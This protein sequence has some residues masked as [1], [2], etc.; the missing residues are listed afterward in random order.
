VRR[1]SA[2]F[3]LA[4]R[5]AVWRSR[6]LPRC[7]MDA[8]GAAGDEYEPPLV[9]VCGVQV[10]QLPPPCRVWHAA[11]RA[12]RG[13]CGG[14][15]LPTET[16]PLAGWNALAQ[17]ADS[18]G[19]AARAGADFIGMIFVPKSKRCMDVGRA[20]GVVAAVAALRSAEGP[21]AVRTPHYSAAASAAAAPTNGRLCVLLLGIFA[22][23]GARC[24]GL[25]HVLCCAAALNAGNASPAGK[26]LMANAHLHMSVA[27][28][29]MR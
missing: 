13:T 7:A 6:T 3:N 12:R 21:P 29:I 16:G 8:S 27:I 28:P 24:W 9:K 5:V 1:A 2:A 23:G 14:W 22:G 26:Q 25:V 11:C 17:D 4:R 18:A 19:T 15:R 20:K 10:R